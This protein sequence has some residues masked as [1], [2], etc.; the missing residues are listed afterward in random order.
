MFIFDKMN[1]EG[2]LIAKAELL[3]KNF[4]SGKGVAAER[5]EVVITESKSQ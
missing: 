2:D 3:K 1:L 5:C 4:S